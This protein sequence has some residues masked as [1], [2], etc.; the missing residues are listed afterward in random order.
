MGHQINCP[1]KCCP[2]SLPL[3]CWTVSMRKVTRD[4]ATSV[5][6]GGFRRLDYLKITIFGFALT[7]LWSSLHT[8]VL[9]VRLLDFVAES[10]KNTY[11]GLISGTGLILAVA[12]QP[13][14]GAV[15][16]RSSFG[17][18][19][20]RPYILL[21]TILT[22]LFLPGI[23]FAG[24]YAALFIIYCL[25]QL[26]SNTAQGPYQAL[27]PD[28]VPEGKRGLASGV[29]TLLEFVGGIALLRVVGPFMDRYA[30]GAG[31]SWLWLSLG[32]LAF[33]LLGA[34]L[35]TTLMV[36]E[37]PGAASPG[38]PLLS[39]LYQSFKIDLKANRDFI[40]FLVSR[41]IIL[42][43]FAALQRF[44]LYFLMD[45]VGVTN[46]AAVTADLLIVVGV[47]MLAVVYPAG[48]LSDRVGRKPIV[49]S[50]GLFSALGIMLLFFSTGYG[51]ILLCGALLGL[52]SGAFMST[53]WALAID[54]VPKGEEA[55]YL[56]LANTA[57][58]GGAALALFAIGP[59]IDFLNAYRPHLGY[60]AMFL[61]C[62]I[63]FTAGSLLVMKI[64]GG[65]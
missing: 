50:S 23:G 35:A 11:L 36:K 17:W 56:G 54:L 52:S 6:P 3:L 27:I 64:K 40:W 31:V 30:T 10:Q 42:M 51:Y 62:F 32:V 19:R 60:Q 33:I 5:S 47:C 38:I 48:R 61:V 41:L 8:I 55:R 43:A 46:P 59:M 49:V 34:M 22:L 58:A 9:Q 21:G 26:S 29:K 39:T 28:L 1:L 53:N 65:R 63:L 20:R 18:G 15:S 44:A 45:V 7:A 4:T 2:L 13:I 16:D 37:R 57:T 25:L 14:A 24:S 12:V